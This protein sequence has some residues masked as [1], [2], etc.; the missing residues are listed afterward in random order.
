MSYREV[1]KAS[2]E[3]EQNFRATFDLRPEL[4]GD[5]MWECAYE[6][7]ATHKLYPD[8]LTAIGAVLVRKEHCDEQ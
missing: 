6:H 2:S 8:E 7:A 3:H 5:P 1:I 4:K